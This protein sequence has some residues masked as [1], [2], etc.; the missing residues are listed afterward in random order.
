[1]SWI[2]GSVVLR[3]VTLCGTFPAS[4]ML[5]RDVDA[6][7][8]VWGKNLFHAWR[9][10]MVGKWMLT[11]LSYALREKSWWIERGF[12]HVSRYLI[13]RDIIFSEPISTCN[14]LR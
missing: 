11:V 8:L 13:R 1:M 10:A 6:D 9:V 7:A 12:E 5:D 3:F 4:R 14:Y 2:E